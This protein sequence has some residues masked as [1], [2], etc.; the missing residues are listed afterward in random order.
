MK[1]KIGIVRVHI[2]V[3]CF[4][5]LGRSLMYNMERREPGMLPWGTPHWGVKGE[6]LVLPREVV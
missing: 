1:E 3:D 4:M 5:D 6:N 2:A